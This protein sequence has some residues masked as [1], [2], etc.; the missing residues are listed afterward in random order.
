MSSVVIIAGV[1]TNILSVVGIVITNKYIT[2]VDRFH[3]MVFLSFLHFLFTSIGTRVL[4]A[5]GVFSYKPAP[6][7]GILPVA[8]GSL[9]SVGFMNLNLSYNSVG[10]YQ[11]CNL[12]FH[13]IPDQKYI[14]LNI[15]LLYACFVYSCPS[16]R[17]FRSLCSS[18]M[19][20]TSSQFLS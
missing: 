12:S 11:V 16:W 14:H 19:W 18:N 15:F 9:L 13:Q 8:A 2:E 20:L 5:M 17:V 4:L 7:S 3:Y 1:V 6:L 10:F